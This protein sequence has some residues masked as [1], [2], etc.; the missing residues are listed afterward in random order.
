ML[1]AQ[2]GRVGM[3]S[4]K[5]WAEADQHGSLCVA[6][7]WSSFI[8]ELSMSECYNLAITKLVKWYYKVNAPFKISGVSEA[9]A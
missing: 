9:R 6:A 5:P 2:V 1:R 7:L 4:Y 3:P 8:V